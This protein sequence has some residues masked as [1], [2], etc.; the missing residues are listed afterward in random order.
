M[1]KVGDVVPW[2]G[3]PEGALVAVGEPRRWFFFVRVGDHG[4]EV[5]TR[6]GDEWCFWRC[7]EHETPTW[8]PQPWTAW[9][10]EIPDDPALVCGLGLTGG[11]SADDLH[12][13]AWRATSRLSAE[14]LARLDSRARSR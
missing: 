13:L 4:H 3:V 8:S 6:T 5:A 11:E 2:Q 7:G 1:V 9:A 12:E 14:I 10:E